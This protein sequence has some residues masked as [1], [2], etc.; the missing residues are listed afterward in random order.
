MN[1]YPRE[2]IDRLGVRF[3]SLED[4]LSLIIGVGS[5]NESVFDMSKRIVKNHSMNLASFYSVEQIVE[6]LKIPKLQAQKISACIEIGRR[7]FDKNN[8]ILLNSKN[9]IISNFKY[10]SI[11]SKEEMYLVFLDEN[12]RFFKKELIYIG[13]VKEDF[14]IKTIFES[15][16]ESKINKFFIIYGSKNL[17]I[18][19]PQ[20]IISQK[21]KEIS[22]FLDINF[23][24]FFIINEIDFISF[25]DKNLI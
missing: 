19:N 5:K 23:L 21:I 8:D 16:L 2:K 18:K 24:D 1:E 12:N 11:S 7:I 25:K 13:E 20:I 22:I 14:N 6:L 4:L 17:E 9:K 10:L 15:L 3:L